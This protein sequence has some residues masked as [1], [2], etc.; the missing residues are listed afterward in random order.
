M[1]SR[2]NACRVLQFPPGIDTG[3]TGGFDMKLNNNVYNSLRV[4]S[5]EICSKQKAKA[6]PKSKIR[7][8]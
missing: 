5:H 7:T 6:S 4:H 8:K 2:I 1:S 3:D